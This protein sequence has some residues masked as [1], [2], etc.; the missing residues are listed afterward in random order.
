MKGGRGNPRRRRGRR[1]PGKW[2]TSSW[3]LFLRA[4]SL[5]SSSPLE[6]HP[7]SVYEISSIVMFDI[8]EIESLVKFFFSFF[9]VS[10]LDRPNIFHPR[11]CKHHRQHQN[12][13][14]IFER[15]SEDFCV[16][17]HAETIVESQSTATCRL[18]TSKTFL[19]RR[20]E[21]SHSFTLRCLRNNN[22]VE[23]HEFLVNY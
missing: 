23:A 4:S 20:P 10:R 18:I 3:P 9:L 17:S 19:P 12:N 15:A 5:L 21:V 2:P 22:R 6:L 7:L 1:L 8:A 16:S 11:S 13:R 14:Q